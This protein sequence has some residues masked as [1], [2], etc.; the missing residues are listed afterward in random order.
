MKLLLAL[1]V[2]GAALAIAA[3]TYTKTEVFASWPGFERQYVI[4]PV[5]QCQGLFNILTAGELFTC[6]Q[7][8]FQ[9]TLLVT[10][11]VDTLGFTLDSANSNQTY[12]CKPATVSTEVALFSLVPDDIGQSCVTTDP[13]FFAVS[14]SAA[15]LLLQLAIPTPPVVVALPAPTVTAGYTQS[16]AS[17]TRNLQARISFSMEPI[18][19]CTSFFNFLSDQRQVVT[20]VNADGSGTGTRAYFTAANAILG[21]S[22]KDES[23]VSITC[24]EKTNTKK[25]NVAPSIMRLVT[26]G[27]ERGNKQSFIQ[28]MNAACVILAGLA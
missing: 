16:Y 20:C 26:Q 9:G 12:Q 2:A 14:T 4:L 13:A 18:G 22:I 15:C 27:T 17:A 6:H 19:Q 25:V 8:D 21:V 7:K 28:G 23:S 24:S 5:T 1:V 10:A 3:P 11:A